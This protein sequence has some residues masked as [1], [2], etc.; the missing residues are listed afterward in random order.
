MNPHSDAESN[1]IY[2]EEKKRMMG[3]T[4]DAAAVTEGYP[5]VHSRTISLH[6]TMIH[7]ESSG[8]YR[9]DYHLRIF[10]TVSTQWLF[11]IN[12]LAT[13]VLCDYFYGYSHHCITSMPLFLFAVTVTV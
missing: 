5:C 12:I 4:T 11:G 7:Y 9:Y 6:C 10:Q 1:W 13:S 2:N 8:Q 3:I